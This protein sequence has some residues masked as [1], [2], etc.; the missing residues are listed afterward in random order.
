M[1]VKKVEKTTP[2]KSRKYWQDKCWKLMSLIVRHTNSK[3]GKNVC[4]TCKNMF[5]IKELQA[6][7]RHHGKLDF[8]QRNL[9]P[10]CVRC[11]HFLSG[12][13]G[14]YERNL[15]KDYGMKWAEKLERDS[16]Q[17]PGY[18]KV[19]LIKIHQELTLKWSQMNK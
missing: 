17:H 11:N 10:Q 7:H 14:N 3:E 4:Y 18:K 15:I 16:K 13:L 5:D 8:D 2:V 9:K 1:R 12:N 6:G 19:D